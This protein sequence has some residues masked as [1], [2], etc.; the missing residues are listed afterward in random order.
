MLRITLLIHSLRVG[1]AEVQ[2]TALA[3][4][5]DRSLFA[6]TIVSFYGDGPLRQQLDAAGIPVLSADKRG[7]RDIV[8]FM[9]RIAGAI[10][11]SRPDIIYAYSDFPNVVAALTKWPGGRPKIVW[12]VRASHM[13]TA[14]RDFSWRLNF[15]LEHLLVH[16]V[17]RIIANSQAGRRHMI[18]R[19]LPERKIAVV[20]NGIDTDLYAPD[21]QAR[22]RLRASLGLAPET[23]VVGLV[24][25]LDPMKDHPTF[26]RA[27]AVFLQHM[28][29][30]RFVCVGG[31]GAAYS[32]QLR[33]MAQSLDLDG[34]V[35][36]TDERNDAA[37]LFNA[38]DV[39]T[40]TSKYGEGFPNAVGEAMA[41]GVP[42]VVTDAGDAAD[43][44]DDPSLVVPIGAADALAA[45]WLRLA[46]LPAEGRLRIGAA[47]RARVVSEF[48]RAK[49]IERTSAQFLSLLPE[50]NNHGALA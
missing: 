22:A 42:C 35:I 50:A 44:V 25:R 37:A 27:A 14:D 33:A 43:I 24:A 34:K 23:F 20:P 2:L 49:M 45:T 36:W 12:G 15:A 41:C 29:D 38:F 4:G 17:A 9:R 11:S 40:L 47:G 16:R 32:Q 5:L 30:A 18:E 13:P 7:Q 19:G 46:R 8:G 3:Q 28:P 10:R 31:G 21:L 48:P 26:L 1:G 6:P 39:S